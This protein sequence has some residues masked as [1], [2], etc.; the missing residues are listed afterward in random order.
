[1]T[2]FTSHFPRLVALI[3]AALAAAAILAPSGSTSRPAVSRA[4]VGFESNAELAKALKRFPGARIVRR[5]P[6]MKTVEVELPGHA[7]ELHGLPGIAYAHQPR[8]RTSKVEPALAAVFRPGLPY[9]WQ[10]VATRVNEVPEDVLRAASAIKIAVIDTGVDVTHPDIA[11]KSARDLGHRPPPH[12]RAGPR[13]PRDVRLGARRRL[14]HERRRDR[15]IRRRRAAARRQGDRRGWQL[16]RRRRG[17]RDRLRGRPRRQDHQPE[18]RRRRSVGAGNAGDPVRGEPQ[19]PSRRSRRKRVRGREPDRVSGRRAPARGLK[20]SGRLRPLGRREHDVRQAGALLEHGHADLARRAWRQRLRGRRG[21]LVTRILAA[22]PA[23]R[24]DGRP[25]RVVERHLVLDSG[26]RR[27]RSPRLGRQ[28]RADRAAGLRNPQG[29]RVGPRKVEP[30]ARLR[31][32]RR[33]FGSRRRPGSGR[34]GARP[35]RLVA[36][37]PPSGRTAALATLVRSAG[38]GVYASQSI[39]VRARRP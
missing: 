9:E 32:D 26:S 38:Y 12:E 5:L 20:R 1:M 23:A 25:L 36:E 7:A 11:A 15:R 8:L 24:L 22:L 10:Y 34:Q 14:E 31:R 4:V 35:S 19:R 37:P 21:G 3:V 33:R 30:A 16:Q 17:G 29:D 2:T 18:H 13:R 39:C 28:P 6:H 27:C